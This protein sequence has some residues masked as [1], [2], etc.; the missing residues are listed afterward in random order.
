MPPDSFFGSGTQG[1]R[2]VIAPA[3]HLVVARLGRSE[4]WDTFDIRG[5]MRLVA[6][7]NR[8]L[9]GRATATA[10]GGSPPRR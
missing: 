3:E 9:N 5:L 7:A 2:V 6:D 4:D 8:E 10:R 1:Q